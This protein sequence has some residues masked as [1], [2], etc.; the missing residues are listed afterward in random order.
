MRYM[1]I[2]QKN[3]MRSK[4]FLQGIVALLLLGGTFVSCRQLPEEQPELSVRTP[5]LFSQ[6]VDAVPVLKW[7]W[8]NTGG[9][10]LPSERSAEAFH[11]Y[12]AI[13]NPDS[14]SHYAS[15]GPEQFSYP[16]TDLLP[17]H[18]Y[19]FNVVAWV[20][21]ANQKSSPLI[22]LG[23][24]STKEEKF[25]WNQP[26][27]ISASHGNW[28]RGLDRLVFEM[29][30]DDDPHT[31]IAWGNWES[32]SYTIL[33]QGSDPASHDLRGDIAYESLVDSGQPS[34]SNAILTLHPDQD[35]SL[36]S[37]FGG[38]TYYS[39]P[40]W[41]ASSENNWMAYVAV[42]QNLER[43]SIFAFDLENG[44]RPLEIRS[45]NQQKILG[46]AGPLGRPAWQKGEEPRLAFEIFLPKTALGDST[47]WVRDIESSEPLS[48][49]DFSL[50][51]S[52]WD[53]YAPTFSPNGDKLAFLSNRSG[54]AEIWIKDHLEDQLFQL[55]GSETHPP[56]A[57]IN[58]LDW[59]TE[60]DFILYTTLGEDGKLKLC[61]IKVNI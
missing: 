2:Q 58:K 45:A 48:G 5:F 3:K 14:L 19:Y 22:S 44:R 60:G 17:Q 25:L 47:Y 13:D 38:D 20:S 9:S 37:A 59:S 24:Q 53:D 55:S 7:G 1:F 61:K 16:L 29:R 39:D 8:L 30:K 36:E 10:K 12:I 51:A 52:S 46:N 15:L 56:L 26:P 42:D 54:K 28:D 57:S 21:E 11:L 50:V 32:A 18:I 23:I 33:A 34:P 4:S 43:S 40:T 27:E 31:Y 49:L 6:R 35:L 41:S